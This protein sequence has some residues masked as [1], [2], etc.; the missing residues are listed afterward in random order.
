VAGIRELGED[1]EAVASLQ[2][3]KFISGN[4]RSGKRLAGRWWQAE[5]LQAGF[6]YGRGVSIFGLSPRKKAI[7]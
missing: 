6:T 2:M 4:R 1:A 5:L 7:L 3:G